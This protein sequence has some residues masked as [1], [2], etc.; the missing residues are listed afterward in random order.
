MCC[1]IHVHIIEYYIMHLIIVDN[2]TR[3]LFFLI[4]ADYTVLKMDQNEIMPSK[5]AAL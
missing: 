2:I 1:V 3:L 4:L 5:I